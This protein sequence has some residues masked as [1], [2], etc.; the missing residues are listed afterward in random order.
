MTRF[1]LMTAAASGFKPQLAEELLRE[2]WKQNNPELQK[3]AE[4]P[5]VKRT[6]RC[7]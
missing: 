2:R 3:V 4:L 7:L 5:N 6:H 1:E